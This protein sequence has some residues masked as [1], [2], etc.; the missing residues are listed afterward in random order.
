MCS[1]GII[2]DL[3]SRYQATS[4]SGSFFY[5]SQITD[6]H[7][8]VGWRVKVWKGEGLSSTHIGLKA[9]KM[10]A[11][12]AIT[13]VSG[14]LWLINPPR[15]LIGGAIRS[16]WALLSTRFS[17]TLILCLLGL[18]NRVTFSRWRVGRHSGRHQMS[19][20]QRPPSKA[21]PAGWVPFFWETQPHHLHS[22]FSSNG[23]HISIDSVLIS[24]GKI[25]NANKMAL[26]PLTMVDMLLK[27][28]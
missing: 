21:C 16:F 19:H 4:L 22:G 25:P 27:S 18:V 15:V 23:C 8:K 17:A 9:I 12:L 3:N 24:P 7:L 2:E 14:C 6:R 20:S 13:S 1:I 11:F 28:H 5:I 10:L 26:C